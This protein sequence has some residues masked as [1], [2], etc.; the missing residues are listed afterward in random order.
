[1]SD[2]RE[3]DRSD[4]IETEVR[5]FPVRSGPNGEVCSDLD[6]INRHADE[7]NREAED[8]SEYQVI[9]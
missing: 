6:L 8:V 3:S 7:L 4:L 9:P 5:D 2:E 1:V